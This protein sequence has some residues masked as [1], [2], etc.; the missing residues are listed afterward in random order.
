MPNQANANATVPR[1][2]GVWDADAPDGYVALVVYGFD[3]RR[4]LRIEIAS[5]MYSPAWVGWLE[6]WL[7]RWSPGFLEIIR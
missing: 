6:R 5:D 3:G 1:R 2:S 4:L 7:K